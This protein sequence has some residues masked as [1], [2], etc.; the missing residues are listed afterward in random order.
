MLKITQETIELKHT[1]QEHQ[2]LLIDLTVSQMVP[3]NSA[4]QNFSETFNYLPI[5]VPP[6]QV[7]KGT[8]LN[9]IRGNDESE[10]RTSE[11]LR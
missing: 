2:A 5:P 9:L 6:M 4:N 1:L 3:S 7:S 11:D 8:P 10:C